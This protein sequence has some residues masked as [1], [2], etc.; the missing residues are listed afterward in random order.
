MQSS[1]WTEFAM[2][3]VLRCMVTRQKH[4]LIFVRIFVNN[5]LLLLLSTA[6]LFGFTTLHS[7]LCHTGRTT[8]ASFRPFPSLLLPILI[9]V[10][11]GFL[12]DLLVGAAGQRGA[13]DDSGGNRE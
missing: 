11:L 1:K 2:K 3:K 5:F 13:G 4:T 10:L 7:P 9:F 8:A 12:F 6:P